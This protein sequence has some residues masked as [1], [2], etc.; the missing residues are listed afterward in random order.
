VLAGWR[1][2][3][4]PPWP[5]TMDSELRFY[6]PFW[7]TYGF[8]VIAVARDLKRLGRWVPWLALVFFL[9]GVGRA[10]SIAAVGAPHPVFVVL[11]AIE[12]LLPPILV[13][14][15]RLAG[16]PRLTVRT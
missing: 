9:G 6:A 4:T 15:W 3:L 10:I 5:P 1:G 14:L 16:G 8:L 12:L 2:P 7:G 11:M 13:A